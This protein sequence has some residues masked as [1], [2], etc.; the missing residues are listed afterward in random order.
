MSVLVLNAALANA[1]GGKLF[2]FT[3]RQGGGFLMRLDDALVIHRHREDRNAFRWG[4]LK[5]E[6]N[7]PV[8][9]DSLRQPF[10]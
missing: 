9:S 7:P 6:E 3:E 8:F 10:A 2:Q 4:T 5:V 1:G